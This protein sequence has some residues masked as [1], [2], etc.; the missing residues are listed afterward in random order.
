MKPVFRLSLTLALALLMLLGVACGTKNTETHTKN[1]SPKAVD[2]IGTWLVVGGNGTDYSIDSMDGNYITIYRNY[3][4]DETELLY[5]ER[6]F[7]YG[8]FGH[9]E[10]GE[11]GSV[12]FRELK[13]EKEAKKTYLTFDYSF[14]DAKSPHDNVFDQFVKHF[15]GFSDQTRLIMSGYYDQDKKDVLVLHYTGYTQ[16]SP[17]QK[18]PID[19][20]L[21]LEKVLPVMLNGYDVL[22]FAGVWNDNVGNKWIFTVEDESS[23]KM[24][25]KMISA[26]GEAFTDTFSFISLKMDEN[27]KPK[28]MRLF[29]MNPDSKKSKTFYFEVKDLIFKG[30]EIVIRTDSEELVLKPE[31]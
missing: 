18:T 30:N 23:H 5:Y 24:K 6:L 26:D 4:D 8:S 25:L 9:V 28:L 27:G 20:T 22:N 14:E 21:K 17:V 12:V 3:K 11:D 29:A 7:S 15:Y 2:L 16:D 31:G 19:T 10:I 1:V 13:A